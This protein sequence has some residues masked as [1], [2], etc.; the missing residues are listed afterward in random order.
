MKITLPKT[1]KERQN[2]HSLS[3]FILVVKNTFCFK[4]LQR[5]IDRSKEHQK[6]Y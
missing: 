2:Y 4:T 6:P 5:P 1:P 3:S